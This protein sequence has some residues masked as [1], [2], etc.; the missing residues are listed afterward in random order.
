[1]RHLHDRLG[2]ELDDDLGEDRVH[3]VG[4]R[5]LERERA[6]A[7]R[8]SRLPRASGPSSRV[9]DRDLF[10]PYQESRS[11]KPCSIA[12]ASVNALNAEPACRPVP[13]L[14]VARFSWEVQVRSTRHR[15]DVPGG[16]VDRDEGGAGVVGARQVRLDRSSAA[17]CSPRSAT[18]S[19]AGRRRRPRPVRTD[20]PGSPARTA[21]STRSHRV[22]RSARRTRAGAPRGSRNRRAVAAA[23]L[24]PARG[25][26][27]APSGP[28]RSPAGTSRRR[29]GRSGRRPLAR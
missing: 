16:G 12:S 8:R 19:P 26:R 27:T 17:A 5:G 2:T 15:E 18:S 21:R 25:S 28:T 22:P 13:P 4:R 7:P 1:M 23:P 11:R 9:V 20:A 24:A 14:N 3:R 10:G 29:D 6:P